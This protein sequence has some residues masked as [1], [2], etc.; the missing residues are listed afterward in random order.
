MRRP[1]ITLGWEP[2][3]ARPYDAG[4]DINQEKQR[5]QV[6]CDGYNGCYGPSFSYEEMDLIAARWIRFRETGGNDDGG[7]AD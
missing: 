4:I 2:N 1:I 5:V 3:G 6:T 7:G